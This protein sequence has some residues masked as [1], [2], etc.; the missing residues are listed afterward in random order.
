MSFENSFL[1]IVWSVFTMTII[2]VK[3]IKNRINLRTLP[4]FIHGLFLKLLEK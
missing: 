4:Q 2:F 3:G 1:F